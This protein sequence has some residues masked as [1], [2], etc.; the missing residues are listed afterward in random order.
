MSLYVLISFLFVV[1]LLATELF[2]GGLAVLDVDLWPLCP[3]ARAAI[4]ISAELSLSWRAPCRGPAA[5]VPPA[6]AHPA[7]SPAPKEALSLGHK[8]DLVNEPEFGVSI[9]LTPPSSS[10]W[11][12]RRDCFLTLPSAWPLLCD[13]ANCLLSYV[14]VF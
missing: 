1:C 4:L 9:L 7:P 12:E 14:C 11:E 2:T 5:A 8:Q 10:A 13:T 3:P 6:P